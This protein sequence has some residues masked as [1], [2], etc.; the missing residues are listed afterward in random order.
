MKARKIFSGLS[1]LAMMAFAVG[2]SDDLHPDINQGG[3]T[4]ADDGPGVYMTVN[5]AMPSAPQGTRSTTSGPGQSNDGVE[6]GKEYENKVSEALI[7]IAKQDNSFIASAEVKAED[8]TPIG[9]VNSGIYK[10][11][12][13]FS[14]SRMAE[15]YNTPDFSREV[16]IFVFC[17]PTEELS[18]YFKNNFKNNKE[19]TD[20]KDWA[21]KTG[22]FTEA[23]N[24]ENVIWNPDNFLMSNNAIATRTLPVDMADWNNYAVETN[25][26]DL[27]GMNSSGRPNQVDNYTDRGNIK[28]ERT[29][30]RFDFRD[31][32][33][34]GTKPGADRTKYNG[35]GNCTYEV[36]LDGNAGDVNIPSLVNIQ[37]GKMALVN[38]NNE[39]YF[40]R[41]VSA[42]GTG[43]VKDGTA[44]ICKPEL[45]WNPRPDGT[46]ASTGNYVVDAHSVWKS[47]ASQSEY[48]KYLNY[49]FFHKNTAGEWVVDNTDV[50]VGDRWG[51]DL[52][53]EVLGEKADNDNDNSWN[54]GGS[55]GDYKIWRYA[56]ETAVPGVNKQVNGISTGIV[57]KGKMIATEYAENSSDEWHKKLAAAI[58]NSSTEGRSPYTDP[59]L[60]SFGGHLYYTFEHMRR[61]ALAAAVTISWD[62][63]DKKWTY[64]VNRSNSLYR[65][66]Y[67]DGGFGTIQFAYDE[68]DPKGDFMTP[69]EA[70]GKKTAEITDDKPEDQTSANYNWNQWNTAGKPGPTENSELYTGMKKA[71]VDKANITIY[72][73]SED[74]EGGW[75]YYCYYYYWNRHNNNGNDNIMGPMEFNVIRNNVYK[76]AVTKIS[77]LGHPRISENDPNRP[78][79]NDPNEKDDIYFTVQCEALPWVVRINDIEF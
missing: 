65:A 50:S 17:N 68:T 74:K 58:N 45:P 33:V 41:H 55:K 63:T 56:I 57:F 26:F 3:N 59:I 13:K 24:A 1:A 9:G 61:A 29:S 18:N 79:P 76:L 47:A 62:N 25:P 12:S 36:V 52:I 77:R 78:K 37:L 22:K 75:G 31:G 15:Y 53:S 8:L 54:A 21:D 60:Y 2:C 7:V 16:N 64:S 27:S 5:I 14:K 46:S 48:D 69:P 42:D 32:S 67:G 39:Y 66:V 19:T 10:S 44:D 70:V 11:T 6:V 34:D 43:T 51:T 71:V 38:M 20:S 40:L 23:E 4:D 73:S 30:A 72:Q 28:V 49:P 35:I